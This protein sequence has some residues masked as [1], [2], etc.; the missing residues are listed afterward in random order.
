MTAFILA[1]IAGLIGALPQVLTMIE[2][3]A[4]ERK[5]KADALTTRSLD[6]LTAGVER[7]RGTPPV[8]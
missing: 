3:R 8:Q 2:G 5:K 1:I 6:E 7:V 4:T